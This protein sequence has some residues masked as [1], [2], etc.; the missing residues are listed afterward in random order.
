M[1]TAPAEP[2][3]SAVVTAQKY[4]PLVLLLGVALSCGA[5]EDGDWQFWNTDGVEHKLSD[6]A[7]LSFDA[8]VYFGDDMTDFYYRHVQPGAS[9]LPAP[10]IE[11]GV[12]Y[13]YLEEKKSGEWVTENRPAA[14]ATLIWKPAGF[15]VSDRNQL[16]YRSREE[17][18]DTWRYRNRLRVVAPLKFTKL[19]LQPYADE[20]IYVDIDE[21]E[22][23]QNRASVGL[24]AKL[25]KNLKT[26]VYYMKKMDWKA[27][28]WLE[29][30]ILGLQIRLSF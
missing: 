6:K 5:Y 27:G 2:L 21:K 25:L 14:C 19:C 11:V 10:W 30:N 24:T 23:Q 29:T 3:L 18:D 15:A 26:D 22:F 16:E 1:L 9:L 17:Q 13:R 20:E 7:R 12:N 4:L 8:E 28:D